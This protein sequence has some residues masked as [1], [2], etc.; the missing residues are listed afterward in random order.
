MLSLV[1]IA[2]GTVAFIYY[3]YA[4]RV[5]HCAADNIHTELYKREVLKCKEK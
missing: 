2:G 3:E 4:P 5:D 1:V